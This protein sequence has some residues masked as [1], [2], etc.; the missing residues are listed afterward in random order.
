MSL[1]GFENFFR[2]V[3]AS[4]SPDA[5]RAIAKKWDDVAKSQHQSLGTVLARDELL[6][7]IRKDLNSISDSIGK[8]LN[9]GHFKSFRQGQG[10]LKI[11]CQLY[12]W[13]HFH[14]TDIA[15]DLDEAILGKA[16]G[17][18]VYNPAEDP[19]YAPRPSEPAPTQTLP[20]LAPRLTGARDSTNINHYS[21]E[22]V[23][24]LGRADEQRLLRDFLGAYDE[25]LWFQI[26][27]GGGQGKSRLAWE[28]IQEAQGCRKLRLPQKWRAGFLRDDDITDFAAT[29]RHWV[30]AEPT[31]IVF[32]YVLGIEKEIGDILHVLSCRAC[33][34]SHTEPAL[35]ERVR[36]L[37]L[38]RQAWNEGG[39]TPDRE[40]GQEREITL[41]PSRGLADWYSGLK[42]RRRSWKLP[43]CHRQAGLTASSSRSCCSY[44]YCPRSCGAA[45]DRGCAQR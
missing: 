28:L 4:I 9:E 10:D 26:A 18:Q 3:K 37:L 38:E 27:G 15:A 1:V 23:E 31:L 12:Y 34:A 35:G 20:L 6:K 44:P 7:T 33:G 40:I 21:R 41:S 39:L 19:R 11:A 45:G 36:V 22:L 29:C 25:F 30:P 24:I 13:F 43:L 17:K 14:H 32:D 8:S 2:D 16:Y 42:P 5:K